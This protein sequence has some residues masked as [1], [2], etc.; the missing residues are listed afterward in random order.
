MQKTVLTSKMYFNPFEADENHIFVVRETNSNVLVSLTSMKKQHKSHVGFGKDQNER[1]Q[2]MKLQQ[3]WMQRL[4]T[5]LISVDCH[6][7][8]IFPGQTMLFTKSNMNFMQL[9]N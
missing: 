6:N 4:S 1:V 8:S 7:F 5:G 3:K 2:T 9:S